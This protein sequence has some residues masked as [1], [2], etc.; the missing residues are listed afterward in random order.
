[1]GYVKTIEHAVPFMKLNK[2]PEVI[3]TDELGLGLKINAGTRGSIINISSIAG[4]AA[5][6][7]FL[8]YCVTKAVYIIIK[9]H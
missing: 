7:E 2:I 8:P 1:M 9:N 3:N 5:V 4:F 6:R